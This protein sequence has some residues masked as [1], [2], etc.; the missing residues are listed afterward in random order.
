MHTPYLVTPQRPSHTSNCHF[1]I[2]AYFSLY[3][4]TV[5]QH[6]LLKST[7]TIRCIVTFFSLVS[8]IQLN[9]SSTILVT[10]WLT[11]YQLVSGLWETI[12]TP[13]LSNLL[14]CS[15]FPGPGNLTLLLILTP[16]VIMVEVKWILTMIWPTV[17]ISKTEYDNDSDEATHLLYF[18]ELTL[19]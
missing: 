18:E 1:I 13:T 7:Y 3:I 9:K 11:G 2:I 19:S 17:V 8:G 5:A 10:G 14:S 6:I 12:I 16:L 15:V 4:L